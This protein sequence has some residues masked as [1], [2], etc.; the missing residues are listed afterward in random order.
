MEM[1][2]SALMR[3]VESLIFLLFFF[4]HIVV[5]VPTFFSQDFKLNSIIPKRPPFFTPSDAFL[6]VS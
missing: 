1:R 3:L 5:L 4:K 2:I 6:R